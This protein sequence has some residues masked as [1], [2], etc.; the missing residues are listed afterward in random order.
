MWTIA[1]YIVYQR[2]KSP[3]LD[4]SEGVDSRLTL[5]QGA[6]M[7][8]TLP[9]FK[10][11]VVRWFRQCWR[12]TLGCLGEGNDTSTDDVSISPLFGITAL[13]NAIFFLS[14][15]VVIPWALTNG[16]L[17]SPIVKSR[18]TEQCLKAERYQLVIDFWDNLLQADAILEQCQNRLNDS[19]NSQ[20]YLSKPKVA[21]RLIDACPFLGDGVCMNDTMTLEIMHEDIGAYE[22]GVN[23]PIMFTMNHRI[24]CAPVSLDRFYVFR[25]N[26]TSNL[27]ADDGNTPV[28]TLK[29]GRRAAI[30]EAY[31][32]MKPKKLLNTGLMMECAQ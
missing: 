7:R 23:S 10:M 1:R 3:R 26:L 11:V 20:Y 9:S 30:L 21:S 8:E 6:A 19:C 2:S 18:V 25:T 4:G 5:S 13:I 14:M 16:S 22:A 28:V 24:R 27:T 31:I 32:S 15:G 29:D 17:E 12:S